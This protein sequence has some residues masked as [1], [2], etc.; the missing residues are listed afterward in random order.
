MSA[1][2]YILGAPAPGSNIRNMSTLG[3]LKD[4]WEQQEDC[5][6]PGFCSWG[7]W[8]SLLTLKMRRVGWIET[9]ML[10]DFLW[11]LHCVPQPEPSA[12]SGPT[13]FTTQLYIKA[14]GANT[15]G[16]VQL[17]KTKE[18]HS[19]NSISTATELSF[20]A[21]LLVLWGEGKHKVKGNW[22][23]LASNLKVST[24]ATWDSTS[25]PV[26]CC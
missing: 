17:W 16:K 10:T 20:W 15:K 2:S 24:P 25:Y 26:G 7:V 8:K 12:F 14:T 5:G 13:C 6:K 19:Q 3:L 9:R 18:A 22:A 4:L 11:Q 1:L 21:R 23:T